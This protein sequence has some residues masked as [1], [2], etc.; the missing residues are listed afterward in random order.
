MAYSGRQN[1][2]T[3]DAFQSWSCFRVPGTAIVKCS[4]SC[5]CFAFPGGQTN[6]GTGR[7]VTYSFPQGYSK[8]VQRLA[9]TVISWIGGVGGCYDSYIPGRY[10]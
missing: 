10:V 5:V 1:L 7:E 6:L 3:A 2:I 4:C 9:D 8:V